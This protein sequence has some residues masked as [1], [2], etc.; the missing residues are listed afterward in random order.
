MSKSSLALTCVISVAAGVAIGLG[1]SRSMLHPRNGSVRSESDRAHRV[2]AAVELV[3]LQS[4]A[5]GDVQGAS[6]T[7]D[8]QLTFDVA[9]LDPDFTQPVQSP[10]LVQ[11]QI[12]SIAHYL[13]E[14]PRQPDGS[15]PSAAALR[16]VATLPKV[17]AHSPGASCVMAKM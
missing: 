9:G 2:A 13:T 11:W 12:E 1:V 8:A 3:A 5:K 17:D 16:V 7:L 4:L 6:Q 14:H 10:D 15:H